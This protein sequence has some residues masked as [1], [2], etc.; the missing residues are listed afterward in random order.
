[1]YTPGGVSFGSREYE[2]LRATIAALLLDPEARDTRFDNYLS[3]VALLEPFVTILKLVRALEYSPNP[4][5][6]STGFQIRMQDRI[7]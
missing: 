5:F 2:D 1:M 7:F 4:L 3:R 6:P